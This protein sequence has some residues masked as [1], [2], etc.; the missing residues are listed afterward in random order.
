[1]NDDRSKATIGDSSATTNR[2]DAV[3][4]GGVS[5]AEYNIVRIPSSCCFL[6]DHDYIPGTDATFKTKI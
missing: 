1:M 6:C 2:F 3:S 5:G 4:R